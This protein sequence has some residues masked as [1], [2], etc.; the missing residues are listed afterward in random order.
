MGIVE[1]RNDNLYGS[2]DGLSEIYLHEWNPHVC[3]VDGI[4]H[5]CQASPAD[6]CV[7]L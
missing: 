5:L 4:S 6:L 2:L 7:I 1:G 3:L